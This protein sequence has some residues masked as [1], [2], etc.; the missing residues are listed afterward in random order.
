MKDTVYETAT[1]N[2]I[3][4]LEEAG[5]DWTKSWSL[6]G[7]RN[8]ATNKP[9]QGVNSFMVAF[10]QYSSP[11]WGTYKQWKDAECQVDKDQH[12]T[13]ILR[14]QIIK[15]KDDKGKEKV[16]TTFRSFKVFNIQQ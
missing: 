16:F 8:V 13:T 10:S 12:G 6:K 14:P 2:V 1:N 9:Y 11:F 15:G 7:N 4:M 3:K 5:K